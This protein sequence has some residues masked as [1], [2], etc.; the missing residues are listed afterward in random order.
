MRYLVKHTAKVE[1]LVEVDAED[2]EEAMAADSYFE[3]CNS[4]AADHYWYDS[5]IVKI[6]DE[7]D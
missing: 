5:E 6:L 7:E 3:A 2:E 4:P 1:Y